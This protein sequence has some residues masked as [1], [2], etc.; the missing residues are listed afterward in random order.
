MTYSD[1][2][3]NIYT[4]DLPAALAFYGGLLGFEETFRA[5]SS[6][7]PDHVELRLDGVTVAL[8]TAEAAARVHGIEAAPGTRG[9]QLV[10]WTDDVDA[11]YDEL[12]TAGAPSVTPPRDSGNNNRNAVVTD[13]DGNLV[14]LVMKRG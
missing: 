1:P 4:R 9:F 10:L 8:S 7:T 3:T 5:P 2:M 14:E 12:V 11:A 13:P 6:E